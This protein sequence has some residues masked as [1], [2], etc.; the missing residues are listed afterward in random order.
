LVPARQIKALTQFFGNVWFDGQPNIVDQAIRQ[1]VFLWGKD[2][3]LPPKEALGKNTLHHQTTV[4]I[5]A[6]SANRPASR[7]CLRKRAASANI[8]PAHR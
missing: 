6:C 3:S 4:P 1:L 2:Q 5:L 7:C 8:F